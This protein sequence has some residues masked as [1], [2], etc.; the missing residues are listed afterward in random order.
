MKP[1]TIKLIFRTPGYRPYLSIKTNPT[2]HRAYN[3]VRYKK[4]IKP[5]HS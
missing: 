4:A 5:C 3:V 2:R 1:P